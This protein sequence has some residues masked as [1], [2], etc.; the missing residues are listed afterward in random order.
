M[1]TWR[2]EE[3]PRLQ[4]LH[5]YIHNQ[6][7]AGWLPASVPQEVRRISA[8]SRV[9]VLGL[10][11][12]SVTQ[13]MYVDGYRVP[14]VADEEPAWLVWQA[15]NLDARQTGVH[16]AGISYD[17]A[18]VTVLPGEP[19]PV[20]RG[21]S[22]RNMTAVYGDDDD[23]PAW[24]LEKRRSAVKDKHL[25]R[26]YD[27]ECCYWMEVDSTGSRVEYISSEMHDLGKV[28]VVRFLARAD[29][30]DEVTSSFD[31]DL[32]PIQDQINLTTFGLLVVQHYGAFPRQ[33]ITGWMA[34]DESD[35]LK[36]TMRSIW[37]FE[38]P[39]VKIGQLQAAALD[40]YIDSRRD[41]LRNLAAISQIPA[42]QLRGELVNL[43]AEALAAAEQAEQRKITEA[44]TMF[45]ESWEQVLGL[46]N[47]IEGRQTDPLAQVRWKDTEAR[48]FAATVDGL[49]K[50]ATMLQIPV[51]ELWEK[52]P[53]TTQADVQRWKAARADGDAFA[54]LEDLLR[55]Q[56]TEA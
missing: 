36:A 42:H 47:E 54:G 23:W 46:A 2:A 13:S 3:Q 15:N 1:L 56:A 35:Q 32:I 25:Y 18:Y 31:D 26:L 41:A 44:E 45:G 28:P 19:V 20:I 17:I 53:G 24:A 7:A 14:K 55:T 8:M 21:V 6:Q 50:L 10:V 33:W 37:T 39:D 52:V 27:D 38:D 11:V 30:D 43:S 16:R 29:L 22:P 49:G 51:E 9:N 4:R 48:A 34:D 12:Q 40:G 5:A